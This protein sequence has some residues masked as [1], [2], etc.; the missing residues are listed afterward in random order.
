MNKQVKVTKL[1]I[2]IGSKKIELTVKQAKEMKDVLNDMLGE[3]EVVF[4]DRWVHPHYPNTWFTTAAGN[5]TALSGSNMVTDM[6]TGIAAY[7]GDAFQGAVS[8][9]T[10]TLTAQ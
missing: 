8:S 3:S 5:Y 1:C 2:E 9:N 4:R 7:N 10:M 6:T